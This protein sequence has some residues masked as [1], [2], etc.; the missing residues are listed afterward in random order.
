MADIKLTGYTESPTGQINIKTVSRFKGILRWLLN[1]ETKKHIKQLIKA[2]V[3]TK[4]KPGQAYFTVNTVIEGETNS[5]PKT[6]TEE[7]K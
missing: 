6:I 1:R 4:G 5:T 7:V 3:I 2:G